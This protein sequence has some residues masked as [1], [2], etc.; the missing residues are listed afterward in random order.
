MKSTRLFL[1]AILFTTFYLS[2]C[3]KEFTVESGVVAPSTNLTGDSNYLS[4]YFFYDVYANIADTGTKRT[5]TY[6]NLKRVIS[7]SD[8]SYEPGAIN[9]PVS[10]SFTQYYYNAND[11]QPYKK[12]LIEKTIGTNVYNDTI[13]D[14]YSFNTNAQLVSDSSINSSEQLSGSS[15]AIPARAITKTIRT[16]NYAGNRRYGTQTSS[17]LLNLNGN[18][19]PYV[20]KDTAT[21][22]AAGNIISAS[23]RKDYLSTNNFMYHTATFTYD[24]K[25]SPYYKMNI[26][27]TENT[28]DKLDFYRNISAYLNFLPVNN[29]LKVHEGIS[30]S[31]SGTIVNDT[32]DTDDT[33][34]LFYY[35]NGFLSYTFFQYPSPVI[36]T[37]RQSFIYTSL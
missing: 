33:G 30:F 36:Y 13:T 6:D 19:E 31:I 2:S 1:A 4:R 20:R 37:N 28:F 15:P 26:K 22:D 9:P 5:Y 11:S 7:I 32:Y 23:Y 12:F 24:N 25:F 16:I 34:S 29:I 18:A 8:T 27:K 3:Q 17:V 10:Y 21:V 14:F 35:P